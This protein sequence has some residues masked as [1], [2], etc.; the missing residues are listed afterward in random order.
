MLSTLLFAIVMEAVSCRR[1]EGLPWELLYADDLILIADSEEELRR[2]MQ[3]WKDTL[4]DKGMKV[5]IAKTKVMICDRYEKHGCNEETGLWPC[6]VCGL[7][8]GK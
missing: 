5:N 7:G 2:K 4:E 8:V 1:R 3:I 6:G